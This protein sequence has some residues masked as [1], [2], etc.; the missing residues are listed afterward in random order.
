MKKFPKWLVHLFPSRDRTFWQRFVGIL[1]TWGLP[2][3][4]WEIIQSGVLRAPSQWPFF[5]TLEVTGT[6]IG[7]TFYA[8][9]EHLFYRS[10]PKSDYQPH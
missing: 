4:V 9:V 6:V 2:I 1:L 8:L 5:L 3:M 10:F 7:A